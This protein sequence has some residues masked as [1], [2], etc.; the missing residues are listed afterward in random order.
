MKFENEFDAIFSNAALHWMTDYDGVL[1]SVSKALKKSGRFVVEMGCKGN[2][3]T[4]ENAIFEIAEKHN[5]KAKKCWFFPT[6][7]EEKELLGRYGLKVK[8]MISFSRPTLLPNGIKGCL[9]TF[10]A[11]AFVNI[12]KEMHKKLIDEIAEKLENELEKNENG[13]IL[14][15]Y[16]RL[17]FEAVKE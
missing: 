6:P 17:R 9:Q 2:V 12:P 1:K 8:R 3:E 7:E 14:A 4:I 13:Q 15:D 5:L 16:V 10:S 11:P